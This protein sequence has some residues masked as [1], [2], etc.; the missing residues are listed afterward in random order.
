MTQPSASAALKSASG[1]L[2]DTEMNAKLGNRNDT[3]NNENEKEKENEEK[4]EKVNGES[5]KMNKTEI[6][7]ENENCISQFLNSIINFRRDEMNLSLNNLLSAGASPSMT[8]T[9]FLNDLNRNFLNSNFAGN[10]HMN[11]A[12]SN[13]VASHQQYQKYGRGTCKWPGCDL[14]FD[15]LQTFTK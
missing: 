12:L 3:N 5:P 6:K 7:S 4:D 10:E 14:V 8:P 9:M 11:H 15:D 2:F 13:L 1:H